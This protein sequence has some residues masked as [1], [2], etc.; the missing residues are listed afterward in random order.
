MDRK[1]VA[2]YFNEL[3]FKKSKS[4]GLKSEEKREQLF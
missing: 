4:E 1:M 2:L 3:A